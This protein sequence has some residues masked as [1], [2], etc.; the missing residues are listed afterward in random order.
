[1]HRHLEIF[2]LVIF[3]TLS[4]SLCS[5]KLC[6]AGESDTADRLVVRKNLT[7]PH[8]SHEEIYL[9][10][11]QTVQIAA[12]VLSPSQLPTNARLRVSWNLLK[13]KD[14]QSVAR[15]PEG[16]VK[17]RAKDDFSSIPLPKVSCSKL[18]HALD[19]DLWLAYR[20]P[21]SGI[22]A[23]KVTP[24][25]GE[26]T[27]FGGNRWREEQGVVDKLHAPPRAVVWPENAESTVAITIETLDVPSSPQLGMLVECEPNDTPEQAQPVRLLDTT[28]DYSLQIFGSSDDL[29]Y[30]DNGFVGMTGDDWYRLECKG[31][32]RRLLSACLGIP[33][34]QVLAR[35]R[36][37]SIDVEKGPTHAAP[38]ELLAFKEYTEGQNLNERTH[39]QT[40]PHRTAITRWIEPGQSYL[41]RVEAN[42]PAYELELRV[43]RP[44]PF[45]DPRRAIR[46]G[47]YD[48]LA[49]VDAWLTNRPRGASIERRIRDSGN[50]LGTNCMSCHT[51]SG[52]WGPA[53]PFAMG[54]RPQNV[55][56]WRHLIN[57]CYQSMRPTN[58]LV[59]A[60]ANT[61]LAPLDLGDGPAGTRVA[62]HAVIALENFLKPRKLQSKQAIRAA[63]YVLQ[64]KDPGGINA[65][66]PGANVGAGVVFNYAAEILWSAWQATGELKYFH[67]L[68]DKARKVLE[69]KPSFT[70]DL[71]H[72][73]E[74]LIRHFPRDYVN[75]VKSIST[76]EELGPEDREKRIHEADELAERIREQI[77]DD[78]ARLRGIQLEDGSWGFGPGSSADEGK[79]WTLAKTKPDPS[80]TA[81][82]LLAF[83]AAGFGPDDPTVS[84]GVAALL[85]M[86]HPSGLWKVESSTGFVS[87]AYTLHALSRLYPDRPPRNEHK[88]FEPRPDET[89]IESIRRVRDL[90]TTEN[91]DY[92][93]LM[94]AAAAHPSPLVSYWAMIGLGATHTEAGVES[95]V[96]GAGNASKM[97]REAA[98]WGL[99]QTLIDDHGW[100]H[101]FTALESGDDKTRETIMRALVMKVDAVLPNTGTDWKRLSHAF[102]HGLNEDPHPAVR[103][104]ATKAAWQWWIWNPPIRESLNASWLRLVQRPESNALTETAIRYQTHA[105]LIANGNVANGSGVHQYK[106]LENLVGSI[107]TAFKNSEGNAALR[108]LLIKR[109]IGIGSTFYGWRGGD[110]GPGQLGY[111]TPGSGDLFGEVVL[112]NLQKVEALPRTEQEYES[113][114]ELAL[115]AAANVPDRQLQQKLTTY[116]LEGPENLRALAASS[117]SDPKLVQLVAVEEKLEPMHAQLVR[118]ALEPPRRAALSEPLL[119]L[120]RRARWLVPETQEQRNGILKYLL[121]DVSRYREK[122]E[123]EKIADASARQ[124]AE[125]WHDAGWYLAEGMGG[126]I[127]ENPD[128]HFAAL[129]KSLPREFSNA[130][131]KQLWLRNVPWILTLEREVPEIEKDDSLPPPD[132]HEELRTH[133][134]KFFLGQLGENADP[135]NRAEA[136]SLTHKTALRSNPEVLAKLKTLVTFEK[137]KK[138]IDAANKVLSTTPEKFLPDLRV[139]IK[140]ENRIGLVL[141]EKGEPVLTESFVSDFRYF[142]D[143]VLPEMSGV[144]RTDQR[145]CMHCHGVSG[146]TP[147][148]LHRPDEIGFLTMSSLLFNYRTLQERMDFN[149]IEK[150]KLLRKPLNVQTGEEDGHQ[151]GRRYQPMD[152][153]Y[154]ILRRWVLSQA[155]LESARK[156]KA[157]F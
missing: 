8:M 64:T 78:L 43:V 113:R 33:D 115:M 92:V 150:S 76:R 144:L 15:A 148:H 100:D 56:A 133:A 136:T 47:I 70:D 9:L 29:E 157:A 149:N 68:E 152:P 138:I 54:Y 75:V 129:A 116:S 120:F 91:P 155:R 84:R 83:E 62:G 20:A 6:F 60:A 11:G 107:H 122:T 151:G 145:S 53:I 105:L 96:Q 4:P 30:F 5:L 132:P 109:L 121:P 131:E 98:H 35:I 39:Q 123:I 80:P 79:T 38:G 130:A 55:Q 44:A 104:W 7:V 28:D 22:Y 17:E 87:T 99:R 117:L 127:A 114:L 46:H 67:G 142:R 134:L 13:P 103:A 41:L 102:D 94:I 48:H 73:V 108:D 12:R 3:L 45:E 31:P 37:Y 147:M 27:L 146:R 57:T 86:Q 153:G 23:L 106:G 97:V 16:A 111:I 61:S 81:L 71:G 51:Q 69:V 59:D 36:C 90:S 128:L 137:D 14:P 93:D 119:K 88:D 49:Q 74:L 65:A 110:G 112:A 118:G 18:L 135:R 40:E 89:L 42:A 156:S 101:V 10:E 19:S 141:D 140:N 66:G 24:E 2:S 63:N 124:E 1:M 143:H 32:E 21:T 34:Q 82:A 52:V 95:L 85:A 139:A 50:L 58:E 126:A 26:T 72:R 77:R 25:T 154:Q 125:K